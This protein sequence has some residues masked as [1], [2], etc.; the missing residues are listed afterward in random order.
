[1]NILALFKLLAALATA[2]T[3]LFSLV[4]PLKTI[5]FTGLQ[6]IGGR[7]ICELRAVL[8]GLFLGLGLAPLALGAVAYRTLGIGYLTI[9]LVR[10]VSMFVDRSVVRS[11]VVS[12]ITE[13]V[14]GAILVV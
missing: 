3:G 11:N 13:I 8:G 7:G 10:F 1:M 14:L 4:A 6:P 2:V 9:A 12:L 5:G